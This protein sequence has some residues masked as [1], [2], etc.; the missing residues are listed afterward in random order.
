MPSFVFPSLHQKLSLNLNVDLIN[1]LISSTFHS[2]PFGKSELTQF[3]SSIKITLERFSCTELSLL[4]T[5]VGSIGQLLLMFSNKTYFNYNSIVCLKKKGTKKVRVTYISRKII[6]VFFSKPQFC[7]AILILGGTMNWV[8][9][10]LSSFVNVR[11]YLCTYLCMY[12]R[13][14][15]ACM[16]V[17]CI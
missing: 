12:I 5:A 14:M 8:H 10:F 2:R 9:R 1:V 3:A 4:I 16:H 7:N 15:Y 11:V 17:L 6:S 13:F